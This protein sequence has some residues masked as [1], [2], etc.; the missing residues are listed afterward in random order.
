[1][2][3]ESA[4]SGEDTF[5]FHYCLFNEMLPLA[6]RCV[7]AKDFES[8]NTPVT[9]APSNLHADCPD[10]LGGFFNCLAGR[11]ILYCSLIKQ[12]VTSGGLSFQSKSSLVLS[13]MR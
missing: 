13:S 12:E 3:G 1:M 11:Q 6:V 9:E 4:A 8:E 7:S 10:D 5:P 2:A